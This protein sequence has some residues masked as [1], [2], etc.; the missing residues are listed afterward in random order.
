MNGL[1][2]QLVASLLL[3]VG[4]VGCSS[5]DSRIAAEPHRFANLSS[6]DQGLVRAGQIREGMTSD[7]VF[8]AWGRPDRRVMQSR[9]GRETELWLYLVPHTRVLPVSAFSSVY[10][11]GPR[12]GFPAEYPL[13]EPV[14]LTESIP[15]R[16][17]E[18]SRGRVIAWA[19]VEPGGSSPWA[20][21]KPSPAE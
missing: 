16:T 14:Y 12:G 21:E 18:F 11:R 10:T 6:E 2:S 3:A 5:I 9:E 13:F 20:E 8:F 19:L 15:G 17:A 4:L 7:A 1:P